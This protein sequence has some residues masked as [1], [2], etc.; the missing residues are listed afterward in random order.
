LRGSDALLPRKP[1]RF[2]GWV[3]AENRKPDG[4]KG[5]L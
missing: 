3:M 1:G 2:A 4:F 5:S